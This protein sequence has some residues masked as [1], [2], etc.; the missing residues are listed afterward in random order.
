MLEIK[1]INSTKLISSKIYRVHIKDGKVNIHYIEC[2]G[3]EEITKDTRPIHP[4]K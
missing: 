4:G 1:G 3:L 2:Y